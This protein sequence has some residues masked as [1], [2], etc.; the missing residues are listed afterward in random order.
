MQEV[1]ES[2][3]WMSGKE[4]ARQREQPVQRPWDRGRWCVPGTVAGEMGGVEAESVGRKDLRF[5]FIAS[6]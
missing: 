5:N 1:R 4:H 6:C 2:A 3:L